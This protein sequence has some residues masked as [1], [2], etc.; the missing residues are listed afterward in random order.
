MARN[1]FLTAN[2][3]NQAYH[4]LNGRFSANTDTGS[5]THTPPHQNS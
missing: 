2:S 1:F 3:N 5:C 4:G